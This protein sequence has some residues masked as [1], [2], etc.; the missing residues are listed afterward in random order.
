MFVCV[1]ILAMCDVD[2]FM[3]VCVHKW[4]FPWEQKGHSVSLKMGFPGL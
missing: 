3:Y 2:V 1:Q 4:I